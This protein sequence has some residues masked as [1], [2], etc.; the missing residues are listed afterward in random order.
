MQMPFGK[1]RGLEINDLEENY[2]HWL[3]ANVN[4]YE[5]LRS[6]V[7]RRIYDGSREVMVLQPDKVKRIYRELSMKW[8]PD[9]GGTVQAM[10]AINEFHELLMEG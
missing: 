1:F 8:H 9:R 3:W 4:L 10:Q 5:P 2:I 6:E 7:R